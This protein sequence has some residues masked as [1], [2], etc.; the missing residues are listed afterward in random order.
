MNGGSQVDNLLLKA[1]RKIVGR[2]PVRLAIGPAAEEISDATVSLPAIRIKD[3]ATLLRMLAN[4]EMGFGDS[5]SEGKVE[6]EGDLVS[7]LEMIYRSPTKAARLHRRL[8]SAIGGWTRF[9]SL[10]GSKKNIHHHY[11]LGNDF[12]KLWLD[13]EM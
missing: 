12:Y 8:L 11:D 10:R 13:N 4:P 7:V 5:F 1:L 6:I 9:N 3:R 2:A